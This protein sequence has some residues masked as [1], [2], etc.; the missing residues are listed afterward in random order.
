MKR[1]ILPLLLQQQLFKLPFLPL[2]QLR[3]AVRSI[4]MRGIFPCL[5]K[6]QMAYPFCS[7][8]VLRNTGHSN[9][10]YAARISVQTLQSSPS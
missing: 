9:C 6:R 2:I 7:I 8:F 4:G 10:I 1:E 3:D 5:V